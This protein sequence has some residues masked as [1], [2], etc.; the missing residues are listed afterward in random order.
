MELWWWVATWLSGGNVIWCCLVH[1]VG[2]KFAS[3]FVNEI[4]R[5]GQTMNKQEILEAVQPRAVLKPMTP[6][7]A[8]AIPHHMNANGYICVRDVPF[9][10]GRESRTRVSGDR[11]VLSERPQ[12]GGRHPNND[13]YLLDAGKPL[14]VSREH[15]LIMAA[16]DGYKLVDRGSACGFSVNQGHGGGRDAGGESALVDGDIIT[17]GTTVSPYQYQFIIL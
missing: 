14:N 11:E 3:C 17:I 4:R 2:V 10:I 5:W 15:L 9:R 7:A 12:H 16:G 1:D 6:E 13:L 8:A